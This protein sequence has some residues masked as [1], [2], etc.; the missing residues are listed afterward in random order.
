MAEIQDIGEEVGE[1][2]AVEQQQQAPAPVEVQEVVP[3]RYRGKSAADIMKM[4]QEAEKLIDRQSR[5]VGEVRKLA[6]FQS[7]KPNQ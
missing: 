4:H 6:D 2:D 3:D 7:Q 1:I 5:E